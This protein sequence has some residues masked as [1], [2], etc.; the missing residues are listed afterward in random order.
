MVVGRVPAQAH[1]VRRRLAVRWCRRLR[2]VRHDASQP[3][4]GPMRNEQSRMSPSPQPIASA[5]EP[6]AAGPA[7]VLRRDA[8][9]R[10]TIARP[11]PA[12]TQRRPGGQSPRSAPWRAV[13]AIHSNRPP[14]RRSG[15]RQGLPGGHC[16]PCGSGS[17]GSPL[18][19]ARPAQGRR[20]AR[21]VVLSRSSLQP[22]IPWP[23]CGRRSWHPPF[24]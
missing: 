24:T 5:D 16:G 3:H 21:S 17:P 10:S 1:R 6:G 12:Q 15:R 2:W 7:N 11:I 19:A 22:P 13:S 23:S 18:L 4:P 9:G 14:N 20:G 8:G